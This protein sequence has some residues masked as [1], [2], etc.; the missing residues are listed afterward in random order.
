[1]ADAIKKVADH[2][3]TKVSEKSLAWANLVTTT[4]MIYGTRL[5][6]FR[7]RTMAERAEKAKPVNPNV[8]PIRAAG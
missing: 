2:Y 4:A 1:M 7:T 8:S 3:D 6:A 5:F